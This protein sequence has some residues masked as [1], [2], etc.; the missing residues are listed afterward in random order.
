MTGPAAP[1]PHAPPPGQPPYAPPP[2]QPPY[3]GPPG[4][5]GMAPQPKMSGM[6]I[7][8]LILGIASLCVTW[9]PVVGMVGFVTSIAGAILGFMGM[10]QVEQQPQTYSGKGIAIAGLVLSILAFL[11]GLLWMLFFAAMFSAAA[12]L[13][14]M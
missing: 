14:G 6:A 5:Y 7:A 13:E 4:G 9:I 12:G 1:P 10:K 11:V 8:S 3:G 2:G